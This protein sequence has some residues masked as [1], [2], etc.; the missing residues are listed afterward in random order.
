L[1][2]TISATE[3]LNLIDLADKTIRVPDIFNRSYVLAAKW[4][5]KW[6]SFRPYLTSWAGFDRDDES[7][8]LKP[9]YVPQVALIANQIVDDEPEEKIVTGSIDPKSGRRRTVIDYEK[10]YVSGSI[11]SQINWKLQ[12]KYSFP[13]NLDKIEGWSNQTE[14]NFI[15]QLKLEGLFKPESEPMKPKAID[16]K[17]GIKPEIK[18]YWIQILEN[19]NKELQLRCPES[20]I[21]S[22]LSHAL[23]LQL[24]FERLTAANSLTEQIGLRPLDIKQ[25][26]IKDLYKTG[27]LDE[28]PFKFRVTAFLLSKGFRNAEDAVELFRSECLGLKK[29]FFEVAVLFYGLY[30]TQD[31]YTYQSMIES[32][33]AKILKHSFSDRSDLQDI[34]FENLNRPIIADSN[35]L[36]NIWRRLAEVRENLTPK[37]EELLQLLYLAEPAMTYEEASIYLGISFD[38]VR[39]REDGLILKMRKAFPELKTLHPYK[40]W[41][42]NQKRFYIY[43]GLV[44]LPSVEFKYPC[45]RIKTIGGVEIRECITGEDHAQF[46][47]FAVKHFIFGLGEKFENKKNEELTS[48]EVKT[49]QESSI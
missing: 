5:D 26:V 20:E 22:E 16:F 10:K 2:R 11:P 43:R 36:A 27:A 19:Y 39:D 29:Y 21:E 15:E 34:A 49:D 7:I 30:T 45:Y 38:S 47:E 46:G 41:T 1:D 4:D 24:E 40:D 35:L 31:F 12:P 32:L 33:V 17:D 28:F 23:Y 42:N 37:Q 8:L 25:A 13:E 44:Y 48:S 9:D 6:G 18:S 3:K 14:K